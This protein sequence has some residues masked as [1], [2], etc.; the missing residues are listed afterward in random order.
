[1]QRLSRPHDD[2][3]HSVVVFARVSHALSAGLCGSRL[4]HLPALSRRVGRGRP[5]AAVSTR[6]GYHRACDPNVS[7]PDGIRTTGAEAD[8][9]GPA[10]VYYLRRVG[11]RRRPRY[12][13]TARPPTP[14]RI[15]TPDAGAS[16]ASRGP[17]E[18]LV[19][20]PRRTTPFAVGGS[21]VMCFH[22]HGGM[23]E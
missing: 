12:V 2:E 18:H 19:L 3:R 16:L 22:R 11:R 7:R 21:D 1:M 20:G 15:A 9:G 8:A 14:V 4:R 5:G 6:A 23:N 13:R 17:T 10:H